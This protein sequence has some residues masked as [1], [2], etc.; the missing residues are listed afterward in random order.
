MVTLV[1]AMLKE[2]VC[3]CVSVLQRKVMDT[4]SY[5]PQPQWNSVK[6]G[7]QYLLYVILLNKNPHLRNF[8][9]VLD[10]HCVQVPVKHSMCVFQI[11]YR[12]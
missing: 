10:F 6:P 12:L 5:L 7:S 3:L 9:I 4:S 1:L 8:M 2:D 11:T